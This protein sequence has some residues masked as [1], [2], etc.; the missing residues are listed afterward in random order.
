M[1]TPKTG[2]QWVH[3]TGG[4]LH[5]D[6]SINNLMYREDSGRV[7]GVLIDYD[8]AV[9]VNRDPTAGQ[10]SKQRTGTKPFMARGLLKKE[11]EPHVF[12]HDLESLFYCYLWMLLK[13]EV[14]RTKSDP[15]KTVHIH[16]LQHWEDMPTLSLGERKLSMIV[17]GDV[18][19]TYREFRGH[20]RVCKRL[21]RTLAT[22]L[23]VNRDQTISSSSDSDSGSESSEEP[24]TVVLLTFAEFGRHICG[25]TMKKLKGGIIN[26]PYHLQL[27]S[28]FG[29]V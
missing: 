5:R 3:D 11:P 14:H 23:L 26:A 13:K 17:D 20:S 9:G 22:K 2:Y 21:L 19:T 16:P 15:T 27:A 10:S 4:I 25:R 6:I 28:L 7:S 12:R 24:P 29:V 1:L 8:M 18:G